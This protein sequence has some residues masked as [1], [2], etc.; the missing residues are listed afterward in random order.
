MDSRPTTISA[1]LTAHVAA[2]RYEFLL[3]EYAR[4]AAQLE[5]LRDRRHPPADPNQA[6][7]AD[8]EFVAQCERIISAQN[9]AWMAKLSSDSK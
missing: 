5:R 1:A 6:A 7:H 8:G 2:V 3:I 4:T 9:E